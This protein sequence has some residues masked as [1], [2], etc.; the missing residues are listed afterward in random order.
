M[1]QHHAYMASIE[2]GI[3]RLHEAISLLLV[4][5]APLE[6]EHLGSMFLGDLQVEALKA[7]DLREVVREQSDTA[8]A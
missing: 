2:L 5:E 8:Q 6:V 3:E 1:S 7:H 4:H